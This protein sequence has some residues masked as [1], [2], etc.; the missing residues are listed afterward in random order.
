MRNIRNWALSILIAILASIIGLTVF[1]GILGGLALLILAIVPYA[2]QIPYIEIVGWVGLIG[3][4]FYPI[5]CA[6]CSATKDFKEMYF[7][8]KVPDEADKS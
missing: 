3:F 5:I 8:G 7:D 4:I 1:F 2:K 6:I